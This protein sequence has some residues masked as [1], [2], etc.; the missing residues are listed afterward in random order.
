MRRTTQSRAVP[1]ALLAFAV[2]VAVAVAVAGCGGSSSDKAGS[3]KKP[4]LTVLTM[5]NG[6]GDSVELEPFANTVARLSGGTLRIEFKNSWREGEPDYGS[7]VIGDIKA[8]KADMGWS[9]S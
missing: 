8:R 1:T 6:N 2:A 9:G 5:A 7:A 3:A 4:K